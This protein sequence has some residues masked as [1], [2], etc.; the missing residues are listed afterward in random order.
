[1]ASSSG[2]YCVGGG[3]SGSALSSSNAVYFAPFSSS[4]IGQWVSTTSY[5]IGVKQQSCVSSASDIY[6]V[7]GYLSTGVYYA[8]LS[9]SGVGKW[10]NT[11]GYPFTVGANLASCVIIG[12][13]VFCVG[14][15]TGPNVSSEVYRAPISP[16]GVGQWLNVT[17][18]PV[19]VFGQSCVASGGQIYC[20]GGETASGSVISSAWYSS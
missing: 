5:P 4:G 18:Y 15:H 19:G 14:G 3:T 8:A 16:S 17:S 9:P 1:V 2:I 10:T 11:T 7:G 20:V 6:C 12:E 13:E